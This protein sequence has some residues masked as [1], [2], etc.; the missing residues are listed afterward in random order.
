MEKNYYTP[1]IYKSIKGGGYEKLTFSKYVVDDDGKIYSLNYN[2][3]FQFREMVGYINKDG[4]VRI[5]IRDDSG[6]KQ[7]V[8]RARIVASTF[9]G[10][11][12]F[13][14][15]QVNHRDEQKTNDNPENLEWCTANYNNNW[16]TRNNR[17]AKKNTGH[18][19]LYRRRPVRVWK[20]IGDYLSLE[21]AAE[22][23]GVKTS[24]N[25]SCCLNPDN[26]QQTVDGYRFESIL[27]TTI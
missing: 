26:P 10:E 18:P 7:S 27:P 2:H 6:N 24:A 20:F 15:A 12:T 17:I 14:F 8:S 11:P 5:C 25:I 13:D 9:F 4:Y 23:I 16:G 19:H 21:E 3:T 1:I 22:A